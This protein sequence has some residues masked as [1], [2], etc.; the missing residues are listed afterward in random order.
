MGATVLKNWSPRD[1]IRF[2]KK[3][4]FVEMTSKSKGDHCCLFNP[5]SKK[6]T[7]IDRGRDAFTLREMAGLVH[8]AGI[9]KELWKKGKKLK[10]T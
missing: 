9:R 1:I 5:S 2:L 7:E 4:G 10:V 8:Q 6:Y 3:N